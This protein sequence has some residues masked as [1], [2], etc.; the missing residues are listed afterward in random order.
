MIHYA[1][2]PA[3]SPLVQPSPRAALARVCALGLVLM[4]VASCGLVR[5]IQETPVDFTN[6]TI[7]GQVLDDASGQNIDRARVDLLPDTGTAPQERFTWTYEKGA[8]S[9]SSVRPGAYRVR[10]TIEGYEP[11]VSERL[12]IDAGELITI[13]LRLR[14]TKG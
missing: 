2:S 1:T 4:A 3:P 7:R 8:F 5:Q 14:S 11:Q 10:A 13:V 9:F 12:V 6:G